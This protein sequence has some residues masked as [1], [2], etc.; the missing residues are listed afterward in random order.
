MR[1]RRVRKLAA[2]S[3]AVPALGLAGAIALAARGI[4]PSR[5]DLAMCAGG[6]TLS[7]IG[8]EV[9]YHRYFTHRSFVAHPA[10]AWVLGV[11]G[12]TAFL[13]PVIWWA[14]I[15]RRHHA[16]TDRDGDPHS[17]HWPFGGAR[18]LW[19]AHAG[20][21]FRPA[22]TAMALAAGEVKDLS[23]NRRALALQRRY[24]VIAALGLAV[25]ALAGAHAGGA[26]GALTGVCWG[27]LVR[28][29][30][31]SHLV[32]AINSL[33]HSRGTRARR[34]RSGHAANHAWLV[35]ATFGGGLHAN[36]HDAPRSYTTR[37]RSWQPDLGGALVWALARV[38]LVEQL[39]SPRAFEDDGGVEIAR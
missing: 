23:R 16:Y 30:V 35:L 18:G 2:F 11:L 1:A 14:S 38:G 8:V 34:E 39:K 13:G 20:W 5:L 6:A 4:G 7:M 26:L 15:H 36:H 10:L 28:V 21:L 19:H 29:F 22:H 3:I 9:G 37:G 32:W 24:L 17:P 33:G 31:V 25:P 27:G 12:S